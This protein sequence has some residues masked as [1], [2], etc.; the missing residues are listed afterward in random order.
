MVNECDR[1]LDLY[2]RKPGLTCKGIARRL[3]VDEEFVRAAL[4]YSPTKTL[5]AYT[6]PPEWFRLRWR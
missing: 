2:S 1:V 3:G 6:E 5:T 4:G